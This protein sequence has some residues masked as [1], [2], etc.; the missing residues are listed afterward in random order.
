MTE[1]EKALLLNN[2]GVIA[3]R[4]GR[5]DVAKG[6]FAEAVETHPQHYAAAASRLA[7]LESAEN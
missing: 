1:T 4:T 6:L 5:T 2:L 7:A 3:L